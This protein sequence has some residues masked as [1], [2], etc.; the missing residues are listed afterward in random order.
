MKEP[1]FAEVANFEE[2]TRLYRESWLDPDVRWLLS[3]VPS[4]MIFDDHDIRDDWNTSEA[5]R[6]QMWAQPWW[7]ERILGGLMS[8]WIYQHIGNL[9]PADL[10]QDPIYTSLVP[11]R[12]FGPDLRKFA[13]AADQLPEGARW[14][15]DRQWDAVRLIVIDSRS[16]RILTPGRREM[17]DP[18][19]WRWLEEQLKEPCEHLLLATSLPF[20]LPHPIH[21]VEAWDEAICDGAWGTPGRWLGE[22][23]RQAIDLEHW[24]AFQQSFARL[25]ALIRTAATGPKPPTT[26]V[27]LSG[28]I[29]YAYVA[30]A[31]L[32]G[33]ATTTTKIY[34]AVCSPLRNTIERRIVMVNRFA[35]SRFGQRLGRALVRTARITPTI[36]W[37]ITDGPWFGNEIA[38][39]SFAGRNAHFRIDRAFA[40]ADGGEGLEVVGSRTLS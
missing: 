10:A 33:D 40:T 28:D 38:T 9:S 20:L 11:G 21:D 23:I 18:E 30:E 12:D 27:A 25:T 17:L 4:A 5:W 35:T 7:K 24:A 31:E 22:K 36:D 6:A 3:T 8:Y 26:I 13:L 1:P 19:E 39:I 29:H 2:Y 16:A 34:Q 14:S 37:T 32:L 15:Y